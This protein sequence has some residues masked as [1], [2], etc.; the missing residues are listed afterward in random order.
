MVANA[1][2]AYIYVYMCVYMCAYVY[3][4]AFDVHPNGLGLVVPVIFATTEQMR[5]CHIYVYMH[6]A[7]Y[8]YTCHIYTY[9]HVAVYICIWQ[10]IYVHRAIYLYIRS[11]ICIC[12]TIYSYTHVNTT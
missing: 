4:R 2:T 8:M 3:I 11:Y 9:T 10:Y 7:I 12:V 1:H 5:N 6:M